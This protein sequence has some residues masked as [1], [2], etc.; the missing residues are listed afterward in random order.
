MSTAARLLMRILRRP[1]SCRSAAQC[2]TVRPSLSYS[3]DF[4]YIKTKKQTSRR[5]VIIMFQ[6]FRRRN[7]YGTY[8]WNYDLYG[9]VRNGLMRQIHYEGKWEG[10]GPWKSRLF[11]ALWNGIEPLDDEYHLGPN[12]SHRTAPHPPIPPPTSLYLP[13]QRPVQLFK[14][15]NLLEI[16]RKL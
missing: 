7:S 9:P 15:Q 11:W 8:L 6:L 5:A 3:I 1:R 14:S 2:S 13:E 4:N 10:V 16:I 12:K